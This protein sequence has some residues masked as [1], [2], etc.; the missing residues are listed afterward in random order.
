MKFNSVEMEKRIRNFTTEEL[1]EMIEYKSD[2]YVEDAINIALKV[3]EERGGIHKLKDELKRKKDNEIDENKRKQEEEMKRAKLA[4]QERMH[5]K[6]IEERQQLRERQQELINRKER[7]I[8]KITG[9]TKIGAIVFIIGVLGS[10]L[11]KEII[12]SN[13]FKYGFSAFS[14]EF[15]LVIFVAQYG[16]YIGLVGVGVAFVSFIAESQKRSE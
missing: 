15:N 3:T 14:G 12:K 6:Q 11:A 8:M 9:W 4:A 1:V 7:N 5:K 16:I 13:P 2:E 10:F